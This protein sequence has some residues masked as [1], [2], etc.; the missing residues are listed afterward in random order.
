MMSLTGVSRSSAWN[1]GAQIRGDSFRFTSR[2]QE[3]A[4]AVVVDVRRLRKRQVQRL[5]KAGNRSATG[6]IPLFAEAVPFDVGRHARR[7]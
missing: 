5:E 6:P 2:P 1:D 4:N 7:P 3:D